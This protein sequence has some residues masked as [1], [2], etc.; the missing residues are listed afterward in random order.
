MLSNL[1]ALSYP[2]S[3]SS[4]LVQASNFI[5]PSWRLALELGSRP[6]GLSIVAKLVFF[7][8]LVLSRLE[9]PFDVYVFKFSLQLP[10]PGLKFSFIQAGG[11]NWNLVRVP[12]ASTLSPTW[13]FTT[14]GL[15][16]PDLNVLLYAHVSQVQHQVSL[17]RPQMLPRPHRRLALERGQHG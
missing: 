4:C 5:H 7:C 13:C 3:A 1:A 17:S 12:W 15:S 11:W 14:T 10:C 16:C 9:C 2:S 6:I 8:R